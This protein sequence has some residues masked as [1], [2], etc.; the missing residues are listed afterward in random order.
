M[1]GKPFIWAHRG[2]SCDAPENTMIAF[3]LADQCAA[4]GLELDVHLSAD[5]WPVV[6]HDDALDR[7]T[8]AAGPVAGLTWQQLRA[9]DAGGWFSS[10]YAGEPLPGLHEVL[11]EFGGRLHINIEIKEA[12]AGEVVLKTLVDFPKAKVVISSFDHDLLRVM[13]QLDANLPLAVLLDRGN[14]RRAID[15][16][17]AINAQAFHPSITLVSR[18][19]IAACRARKLAVHVWT[20]DDGRV[21]RSLQRAGI[22]GLFT[23]DPARFSQQGTF[24]GQSA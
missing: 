18:P 7:T 10:S 1:S 6:I 2:A 15:L 22:N 8:N 14:W 23:N 12:A 11:Q 4:D 19:L 17:M 3:R 9:L 20:V 5:G 16:A 21:A 24:Y 13:R